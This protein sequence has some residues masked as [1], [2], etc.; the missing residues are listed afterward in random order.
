MAAMQSEAA[1]RTVL[2]ETSEEDLT[3]RVEELERSLASHKAM[4]SEC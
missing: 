2:V 3:S 4:L 1:R